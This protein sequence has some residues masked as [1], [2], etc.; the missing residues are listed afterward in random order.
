MLRVLQAIQTGAT[1]DQLM[2]ATSASR[3]SVFRYLKQLEEEGVGLIV[4]Q[5]VSS[6]RTT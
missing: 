2:R 5:G 6:A 4:S 3:R 1:V